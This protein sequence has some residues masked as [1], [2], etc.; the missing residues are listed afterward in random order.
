MAKIYKN[1]IVSILSTSYAWCDSTSPIFV[2]VIIFSLSMYFRIFCP[3]S[4][5]EINN[6]IACNFVV[7]SRILCPTS[8]FGVSC[9]IWVPAPQTMFVLCVPKPN[10][11]ISTKYLQQNYVILSW[12]M[13]FWR[14]VHHLMLP[15]SY[16]QRDKYLS[17]QNYEITAVILWKRFIFLD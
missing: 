4:V 12:I 9:I 3:I 17:K 2:P 10:F 5:L 13:I 6:A 1:R 7:I 14:E 15:F 16:Q 11:Q 8:G